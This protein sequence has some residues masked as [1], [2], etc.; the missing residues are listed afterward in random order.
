MV[1]AGAEF[2]MQGAKASIG[3]DKWIRADQRRRKETRRGKERERGDRE[4]RAFPPKVRQVCLLAPPPSAGKPMQPC[5]SLHE[6]HRKNQPCSHK[7]KLKGAPK[8]VRAG[9]SYTH[10]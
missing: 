4:S 2:G 8:R 3:P 1:D 5:R 6:H 9:E 7:Q 10:R